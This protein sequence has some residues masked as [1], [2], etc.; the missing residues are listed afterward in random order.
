[1]PEHDELVVSG[2]IVFGECILPVAQNINVPMLTSTEWLDG[3]RRVLGAAGS[4][5]LLV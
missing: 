3:D 1:M 4:G 2:K 5:W